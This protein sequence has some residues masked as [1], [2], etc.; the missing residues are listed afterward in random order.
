MAYDYK[1]MNVSVN[2]VVINVKKKKVILFV[3]IEIG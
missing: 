1:W 3:W 2:D